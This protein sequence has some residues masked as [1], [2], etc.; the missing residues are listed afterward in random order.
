MKLLF[1]IFPPKKIKNVA[2]FISI[3]SLS[4][5]KTCISNAIIV[6]HDETFK[7]NIFEL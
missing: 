1:M 7:M 4:H 2:L 3:R 6:M 5:I